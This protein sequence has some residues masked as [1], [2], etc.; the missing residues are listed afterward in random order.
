MHKDTIITLNEFEGSALLRQAG[1]PVIENA[2]VHSEAEATAAVGRLGFPVALKIC[3]EAVPHKTDRGGV[4][5]NITD[6]EALTQAVRE[7]KKK[8]LQAQT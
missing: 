7:M 5:L 8:K 4:I 3:S 1:I 2:L 6:V